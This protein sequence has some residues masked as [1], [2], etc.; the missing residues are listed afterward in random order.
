MK[1]TIT[2]DLDMD[3][4]RA[5]YGPGSEW[6]A[7]YRVEL[8]SDGLAEGTY[9]TIPLPPE[10]Y[11]FDKNPHLIA[12]MVRDMLEEGFYDWTYYHRYHGSRRN[13]ASNPS[14]ES[15]GQGAGKRG[16][17]GQ[18]EDQEMTYRKIGGLHFLRLGPIGL[19]WYW[20]RRKPKP[21]ED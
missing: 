1:L 12:E 17:Q 9:L 13:V 14:R 4:Y 19:C 16:T 18:K 2:L 20:A 6:W 8:V 7:T 5:K 15:L 11:E 3:A 21:I 10:A